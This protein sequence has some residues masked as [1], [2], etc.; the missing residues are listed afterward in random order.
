MDQADRLLLERSQLFCDIDLEGIEHLLDTCPETLLAAGD[1]L[2]QQGA[3]NN[4][5]YLV[6]DGQLRVYLGGRELPEHT[7]LNPGECVGEMSLIDGRRASAL[8]IAAQNSRLLA[9]DHEVVWS[10]I[11]LSYGIARNLL[12][13]LSGRIRFNNLALIS[14]QTQSLE[15]ERAVAVDALTGLHNKRWVA[16]AFPRVIG[17]CARDGAAVCLL[18]GDIDNFKRFN[19]CYGRLNG[20]NLLRLLARRLADILRPQDM[21]ARYGV[22]EFVFLLPAT[23]ISE[24]IK[25]AERLRLMAAETRLPIAEDGADAGIT[26]S[27]GIATMQSGDTLEALLA[28]AEAALQSAK[29]AGR[30]R[31]EVADA[32][33]D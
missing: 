10:L 11:E 12:G 22:E 23:D 19:A 21:L 3:Q 29:L 1:T 15:F 20:D 33:N 13:I 5:L 18:L 24:A 26:L 2:L 9:I 17:R 28:N 8:V 27:M 25:I 4:T 6:L 32:T 14:A 7:L 31:V 30:N 16:E